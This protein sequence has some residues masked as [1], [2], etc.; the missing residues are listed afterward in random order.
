MNKKIASEIAVGIIV[1]IAIIIGTMFWQEFKIVDDRA[2]NINQQNTENN[3]QPANSNQQSV[4]SDRDEHGCIGSAGYLWCEAKQ[5]CLREWEESCEK[6]Y[7][8]E[9]FK[10]GW[11][12]SPDPAK[13]KEGIITEPDGTT[14]TVWKNRI[15]IHILSGTSPEIVDD[16]FKKIAELGGEIIGGD[17][18]LQSLI[19]K[20]NNEVKFKEEMKKLEL[21]VAI[22]YDMVLSIE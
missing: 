17:Y 9:D 10:E 13:R 4:G 1:L 22:T 6:T 11:S 12:F 7:S 8:R 20:T 14:Y 5:K 2:T 3:K 15:H 16:V 21:P 18:D 19:V